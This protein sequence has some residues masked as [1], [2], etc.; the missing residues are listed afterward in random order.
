M[1][2]E[3][4]QLQSILTSR[5]ISSSQAQTILA[6]FL[7]AQK[8]FLASYQNDNSQSTTRTTTTGDDYNDVAALDEAD[9][10]NVMDESTVLI[11]ARE[12][13]ARLKGVLSCLTSTNST[14]AAAGR[15]S[16][17]VQAVVDVEVVD[18]VVLDSCGRNTGISSSELEEVS[19]QLSASATTTPIV[20]SPHKEIFPKQ[21]VLT[22]E[23]IEPPPP[24]QQP[25]QRQTATTPATNT[26]LESKEARAERRR[27]KKEQKELK[28]N[29]KRKAKDDGK[30]RSKHRKKA[31]LE[32]EGGSDDR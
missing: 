23:D 5:S 2:E 19:S 12:M 18:P 14:A 17:R 27:I 9:E 6:S 8:K 24:Q 16:R 13:T 4:P 22:Q 10:Y 15:T 29:T 26:P 31:K 11:T 1:M 30:Q 7:T 20:P 21:E 32:E 3:P 25:T 28:K